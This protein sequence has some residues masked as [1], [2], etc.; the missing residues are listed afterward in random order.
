MHI[1]H[2][3]GEK[4]RIDWDGKTIEVFDRYT[5]GVYKAYIFVVTLPFSMKIFVM[6]CPDM[7]SNNWL[8]WHIKAYEYFGVVT[9]IL[10]SYNLKTGVISNKK[11]ED[12]ILNKS[13][14]E[15]AEYYDT[16]IIPTRVRY[17]KDK[18]TVEGSTNDIAN[19]IFGRLR[20]VSFS[21]TDLR[22]NLKGISFTLPKSKTLELVG[23][24]GGGMATI[25]HLIRGFYEEMK[26]ILLSTIL[27]SGK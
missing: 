25:C 1:N 24:S 12:P 23:P 20:N 4:M 22:E 8:R 21:Y 14:M 17:P 15:L 27:I 11:N 6:A 13:Y 5:G 9:R 7:K 2:K 18:V 26:E 3:T 10:V 16:V 19:Y